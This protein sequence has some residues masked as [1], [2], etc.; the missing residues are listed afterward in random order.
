MGL[1]V[2]LS[3]TLHLTS[4]TFVRLKNDTIYLTGNEGQKLLA[5]FSKTASFE[6]YGVICVSRQRVRPYLLFVTPQASLLVKKANEILSTTRNTGQCRSM[7]AASYIVVPCD[8]AYKYRF[9]YYCACAVVSADGLHFSAF[10]LESVN[11]LCRDGAD[12][13]VT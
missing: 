13:R 5:V 1:S 11:S 9:A 3:V 12:A 10:I 2:C 8:H 7:K 6:I 4:R